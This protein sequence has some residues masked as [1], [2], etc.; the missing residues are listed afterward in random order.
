MLK[1]IL[2]VN[3]AEFARGDIDSCQRMVS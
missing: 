1:P 2:E 3:S